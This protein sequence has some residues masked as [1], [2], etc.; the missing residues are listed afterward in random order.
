MSRVFFLLE[1]VGEYARKAGAIVFQKTVTMA[2]AWPVAL[3]CSVSAFEPCAGCP[4]IC[5]SFDYIR[6]SE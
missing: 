5:R 6:H 3:M 2:I 4:S 1:W